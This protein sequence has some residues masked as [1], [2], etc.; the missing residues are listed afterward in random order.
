MKMARYLLAQ[1]AKRR[2]Y[3]PFV[4]MVE[5]LEACNLRCIGCGRVIEYKDYMD[6]RLTVEQTLDAVHA[7]GAPIVSISGGEPLLHKQIGEITRAILEEKRFTYLCT[8][9]LLLEEKL[10][11]FKPSPYLSFVVHLDGTRDIHDMVTRRPGTYDQAIKG[12]REAIA[13]G[14]RVNTN[15]TIFHGSDVAKLHELF[16]TLTDMKVEGL[17]VSP[18]YAYEDVSDRE[19]FLRR[20]ESIKV[21]RQ[22]LDPSKGFPFYNNPL[23][24]DFLRGE[25]EYGCAAWTT[26]TYTVRGW[27]K[28]C[29]ILADEHTEDINELFDP[30][31]WQRYGPGKDR[32]CANCMMHSSFEGASILHAFSHPLELITVAREERRK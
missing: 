4:T 29:Y 13:R 23:Y 2:K 24:L 3:F 19:L 10:D 16:S 18:G 11:L 28:P 6:D 12:I 14:F 31:L 9:G 17:M 30:K 22:I 5:P 25:R 32:R 8:N 7:S 27:R 1:K 20:Q 21:F 15:T 26:P